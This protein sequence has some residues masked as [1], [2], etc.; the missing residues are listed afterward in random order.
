MKKLLASVVVFAFCVSLVQAGSIT[1]RPMLGYGIGTGKIVMGTDRERDSTGKQTKNENLYYSAGSGI[2]IGVGL[3][4]D[5]SENVA[6]GFDLGY[7]IGSKKET[8]KY[9][10]PT[11]SSVDELKTSFIPINA[12]LK[13]K[14]TID[15]I[16]P[17]AGFGPTI[18]LA[19]KSI[20]TYSYTHGTNTKEKETETTYKLGFG[21][22]GLVGIEYSLS[23]KMV[24]ITQLRV[25]QVSLKADKSKITKATANG[26]DQLAGM[27]I[28]DKETTYEEDDSSDNSANANVPRIENT[29][30]IPANS[31]TA[32]VGLGIKF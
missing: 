9:K 13:V 27:D 3:D 20:G 32:G 17:F 14:T 24:L 26:V 8:N 21:Y 16:T 25:D 2:K 19:P 4:T 1:L 11:Y 10:D 5:V 23:D 31:F 6:L 18:L 12:T 30:T 22:H 15:K 7:S 28:R 29:Y